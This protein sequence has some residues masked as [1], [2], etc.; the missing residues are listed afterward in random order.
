MDSLSG[1]RAQLTEAIDRAMETGLRALARSRDGP[2]AGLFGD[3]STNKRSTNT[4]LPICRDWTMQ[5]KLAG[6]KEMLGIYV[7]GHPLDQLRI[8]SA[9]WPRTSPTSWKICEKNTEVALCGLLTGIV[10][11]DQQRGKTLGGNEIRRSAGNRGCDGF[12]H[13]L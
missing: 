2:G 13:P 3:L 9:I 1:N 5:Q 11:Q 12:R 8:K 7:S 6:E 10:A 4:R